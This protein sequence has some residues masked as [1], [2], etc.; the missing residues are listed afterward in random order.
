MKANWEFHKETIQRIYITQDKSLNHVMEYMQKSQGFSASK[1]QYERQFKI[2]K[3]RKNLKSH[4]WIF[5]HYRFNKRERNGKESELYVDGVLV[6]KK[7]IKK[8]TARHK[9]PTITERYASVPSPKT[10]EGLSIRTP[11]ALC[12]WTLRLEDLPWFNFQDFIDSQASARILLL[13]ILS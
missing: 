13:R 4:E 5:V 10:P 8:E 11:L 9:F 7:K 3:F 1:A 2:W 6:P 12:P